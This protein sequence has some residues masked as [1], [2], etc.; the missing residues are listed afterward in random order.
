[1]TPEE[2][3][4]YGKKQITIT[5]EEVA[6]IIAE[7]LEEEKKL[8]YEAGL[9]HTKITLL[10]EVFVHLCADIM[11]EMFDEEELEVTDNE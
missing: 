1:M 2:M 3:E 5:R 10:C 9:S 8:M 4:K 11:R 6:C 7:R